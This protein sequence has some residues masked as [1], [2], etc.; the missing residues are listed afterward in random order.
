MNI[1]YFDTLSGALEY[2]AL[3]DGL[4]KSLKLACSVSEG[5]GARALCQRVKS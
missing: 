3:S 1:S 5:R 4:A 2:T